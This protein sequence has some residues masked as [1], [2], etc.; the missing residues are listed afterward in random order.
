MKFLNINNSRFYLLVCLLLGIIYVSNAWS[1]SS[2]SLALDGIGVDAHPDF[3]KARSIRSDEW[4]VQTPLT[5]AL[6]L[7]LI[8]I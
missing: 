2:Y 5:Q 3:G 8:H 6:V 7:S 1:P 4:V